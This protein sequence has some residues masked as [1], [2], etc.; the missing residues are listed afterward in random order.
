MELRKF[1]ITLPIM[2]MNPDEESMDSIISYNLEPEIYS[3]RILNILESA[4]RR[5]IISKSKPV[6]IHIKLDTG[7]H[8]LGFCEEDVAE[9]IKELWLINGCMYNLYSLTWLQPICLNIL[10][11]T[12][13]D[14]VI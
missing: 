2:V 9:L 4:I 5:N 10:I 11:Y 8:R 12:S 3:I 7:M 14:Q 6:K 13:S 1:G